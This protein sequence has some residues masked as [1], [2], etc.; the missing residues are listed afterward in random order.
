MIKLSDYVVR[1]IADLGVTD[2]FMVTGGGAMH[3]DDS[4]GN[5][6]RLR[7][8]CN[9]HEQASAIAVEGYA[10]IKGGIGV[11]CVTTGPGGTNTI[12]GVLGQW[13]DSVPALYVLSLIHI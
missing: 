12:T 6:P 5:E 3:L 9:H 13:H 7:Y 10:R 4:I 11:A 2:L 8:V 1:S